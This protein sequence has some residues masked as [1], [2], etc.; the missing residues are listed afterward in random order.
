MS[1]SIQWG[2]SS[3]IYL[4]FIVV[5]VQLS[6]FSSHHSPLPHPSPPPTLEPTSF[7]FV[8]VYFIHVPWWPFPIFPYYSS[9]VLSGYCQ[10]VLYFNVS[11]YILLACLFCWLGST[12]M[13]DH[14]VFLFHHLAFKIK[15]INCC[16]L[17]RYCFNC[18][19]FY[20]FSLFFKGIL[21]I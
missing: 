13:W 19:L 2:V 6:P 11:G 15:S 8:H 1:T 7:A 14:M 16:L 12:Y 17:L 18:L 9:P 20:I 4:F 10:S 5:Q 3:F 21:P